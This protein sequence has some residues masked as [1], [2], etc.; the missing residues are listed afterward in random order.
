MRAVRGA[1]LVAI[2]ASIPVVA[3]ACGGDPFRTASGDD[4]GGRDASGLDAA[5]DGGGAPDGGDG[6][7][8]PDGGHDGGALDAGHAD[9]SADAGPADG[10]LPHDGPGPD[11]SPWI[12]APTIEAGV[13]DVIVVGPTKTVFVTSGAYSGNLGGLAGAD[14]TCQQLAT[15]GHLSGIYKAWLSSSSATAAQRLTHG[16]GPYALMN[17]VVVAAGWAGLTG[18]ALLAPINVNEKGGPPPTTSNTC[19]STNPSIVW[20]GTAPDGSLGAVGATCADWTTAGTS[21]GG[22][23]GLADHTDKSWTDGCSSVSASSTICGTNAALYC[24]EQ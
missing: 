6:G 21:G 22:V 14:A 11:G 9:A 5:G 2:A 20:T 24:V 1:T 13:G 19:G 16:T 18:G 15:N 4:G 7:G 3:V 10:P 23:L 17:G 12:D 8:E